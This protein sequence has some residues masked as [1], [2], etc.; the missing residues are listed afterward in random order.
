[1]LG[2]NEIDLVV[3]DPHTHDLVFV[4]VKSRK[5]LEFD[6]LHKSVN[7][8]KQKAIQRAALKYMDKKH[9][10]NHFRFDVIGVDGKSIS[11]FT[12]ITWNQ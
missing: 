4:E 1:M 7:R 8:A 12:N 6:S 11:H 9:L 2:K 10:V 3:L 5:K